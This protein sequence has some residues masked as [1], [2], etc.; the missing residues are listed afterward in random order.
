MWNKGRAER[1]PN[2]AVAAA[3]SLPSSFTSMNDLCLALKIIVKD[4]FRMYVIDSCNDI[5]I[6]TEKW[7]AS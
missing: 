4:L 1:N 6:A 5:N 2:K 7:M 3:A